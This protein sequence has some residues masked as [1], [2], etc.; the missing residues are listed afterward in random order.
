MSSYWNEHTWKE[1]EQNP[2]EIVLL[3]VGSVEAHGP[4]LPLATDSI[5]SDELARR[6]AM[7]LQQQ[8]IR[9][10]ILPPIHY[11]ITDFSID[12]PGTISVSKEGFRRLLGDIADSL[13]AQGIKCLCIVNSHLEPN[14]ILAIHEFCENY[15]KIQVLFPDKTKKPWASLLTP[16]FKQGACH[17]GSYETS[18]VLAS[19]SELVREERKKLKPNPVN[20]AVLMKQG[21]KTFKQAGASEA[22]FGEPAA[23]TVEE[24]KETYEIL[25]RMVVETILQH[26]A[27]L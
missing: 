2:P 18:L 19:R 6:S 23:A 5:I 25:T 11:V 14:H 9:A 7:A 15:K 16:E 12:F 4:H 20:L 17:A 13:Q 24:G 10:L 8:G 3:P 26:R 22:Y 1:I 27:D 21:V